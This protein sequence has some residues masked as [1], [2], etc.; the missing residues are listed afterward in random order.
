M[1][2]HHLPSTVNPKKQAHLEKG[3]EKADE[4]PIE[5]VPIEEASE[6]LKQAKYL[7]HQMEEKEKEKHKEK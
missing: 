2:K 3:F 6:E 4:K 7:T 5:R 1:H